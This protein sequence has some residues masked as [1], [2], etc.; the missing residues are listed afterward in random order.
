MLT[1]DNLDGFGTRNQTQGNGEKRRIKR[2]GEREQRKP[3]QSSELTDNWRVVRE[4]DGGPLLS[5][6]FFFFFSLSILQHFTNTHQDLY[7][8]LLFSFVG[9]LFFLSGY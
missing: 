6:F 2:K 9:S 1:P 5:L 4:R 3:R 7:S 8:V